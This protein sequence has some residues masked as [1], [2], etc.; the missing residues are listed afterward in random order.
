MNP[1]KKLI[2]AALCCAMML[3]SITGF[4][5]VT[6]GISANGRD[7]IKGDTINVCRGSSITYLSTGQ[8]SNE[9][10]WHFN[11]GTPADMT[12]PGP[13]NITY[14]QNGFDTVFQKIGSGA[15]ADS[16]FIIVRVADEKP[17]AGFDFSPDNACGNDNIQF[18]NTTVNGEPFWFVWD[19][20]DGHTSVDP[21]PTHQYLDAV[22]TGS[23][24]FTV[25]LVATNAN[26]CV[27]SITHTVTIRSV[28]DAS[29]GNADPAV[30][31]GS[32]MDTISFRTCENQDSYIFSFVNNSSTLPVNSSYLI[33]WGDG[34][35]DTTFNNWPVSDTI[36]HSFPSGISRMKVSV[37]GSSGCIGIRNYI[38]YVGAYPYGDLINQG[39]NDICEQDSLVFSLT[40]TADNTPGT[41]YI[42]YINDFSEGQFFNQPPPAAI[43]HRFTNNSCS[44]LSDDGSDVYSNALGAYLL[45]QNPCGV[46]SAFVVPIY[47][48]GKP[49]ASIYSSD[50]VV[51][52][53]SNVQLI[54]T[55]GYGQIV[56]PD[57]GTN[58]TCVSRGKKVWSILPSAGYT[59]N[60]GYAGSLNGNTNDQ[61]AWTDG[62]DSLDIQF[63]EAGTYRITLYVGNEKCGMDSISTSITVKTPPGKLVINDT[64]VCSGSSINLGVAPVADISYLWTPASGLDDPQIPNP[65]FTASY[66]G[67]ASDTLITFYLD[68]ALGEYC[69]G[70]DSVNVTVYR[71]PEITISPNDALICAGD[72]VS[73]T[74]TGAEKFNWSPAQ[75]L[76]ADTGSTVFAKPGTTTVYTVEGVNGNYCSA[77]QDVTVMVIGDL[78]SGFTPAEITVCSTDTTIRFSADN[79]GDETIQYAW[80]V[81]DVLRSN[82]NPFTHHFQR[83]SPLAEQFIVRLNARNSLGCEQAPLTGKVVLHPAP[84]PQI[85]V[86][87]S[88][89]QEQPNTEFSFS[90]IATSSP[91]LT[92]TWYMGDRGIHSLTGQSVTYRYSDSGSF[93]VRL[94]VKD[95]ASGCIA[96]DSVTVKVIYVPGYVQVPNAICPGCSNPALRKFLPLASGLS[97]YR[98]T[99]YTTWGQKIFETTSL[100]ANGSPNV[101]WDGTANGKPLTQ[102]VFT[103][104]IEAVFKNGA[105]WRGMIYPGKNVPV[106]AGFITVVK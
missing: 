39:T 9:I 44:F 22:G 79:G 63:N 100:D 70:R 101:P 91:D 84:A 82:A 36:F 106:K 78:V 51:C 59:I 26:T 71:I 80:Y 45:V 21:N 11:N 32:Y 23:Q 31:V 53:G 72:S 46:N 8:G 61:S 6:A 66:N 37:T 50:S 42:F 68:Y 97:R 64:A 104:Q 98:L 81:N 99:I 3:L 34:T 93:K 94:I 19:F 1:T 49:K 65:A 10:S 67:L 35:P 29:I 102:D 58:A 62:S 14:G 105:E 96:A 73:L 60:T 83:T 30:T 89:E 15:F 75:S 74:A 7:M 24:P 16:M 87:P 33:S 47:V 55:S 5:Q 20:G 17:V 88:L 28:P 103:W 18:T 92:Y 43:G 25:K 48:S 76:S 2:R 4:A 77:R 57:G 38:V 12:G 85:E 95:Q 69:F 13:F 86:G 27:D 40:N 52:A 54:N 41:S 56:I 90:E